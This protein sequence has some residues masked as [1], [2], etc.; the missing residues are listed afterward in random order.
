MAEAAASA[1][2][3]QGAKAGNVT[4]HT[5]PG[6]AERQGWCA[7]AD[8]GDVERN[9]ALKPAHCSVRSQGTER[10]EEG[11]RAEVRA[12]DGKCTVLEG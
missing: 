1:E 7:R 8:E 10:L 12:Q 3:A 5:E 9:Q 4:P 11:V 6:I 2:G